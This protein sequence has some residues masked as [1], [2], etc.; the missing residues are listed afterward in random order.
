DMTSPNMVG[1]RFQ[2]SNGLLEKAGWIATAQKFGP[3]RGWSVV[4]KEM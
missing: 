2:L 1:R 4:K 3:R